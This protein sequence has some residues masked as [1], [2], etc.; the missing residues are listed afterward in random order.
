[1]IP[2]NREDVCRLLQCRCS[3]S[4]NLRLSARSVEKLAE[5]LAVNVNFI[6]V[7]KGSCRT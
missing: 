1:M 5:V 6:R 7:Q 3:V 2:E 4:R